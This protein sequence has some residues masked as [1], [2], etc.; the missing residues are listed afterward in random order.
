MS[1]RVVPLRLGG[2]GLTPPQP[3]TK[4]QM[5]LEK[6]PMHQSHGGTYTGD[7][8]NGKRWELM[9]GPGGGRKP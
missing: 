5:T 6:N 3:V 2:G 8:L 9:G 7:F 1:F 4:A